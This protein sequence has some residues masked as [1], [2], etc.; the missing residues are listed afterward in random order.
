[1]ECAANHPIALTLWVEAAVTALVNIIRHG[2]TIHNVGHGHPY[3]DPPFTHAGFKA[4]K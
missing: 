3:S 1:M 4:T 2:Q